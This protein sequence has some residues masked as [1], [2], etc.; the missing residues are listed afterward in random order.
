MKNTREITVHIPVMFALLQKQLD[1]SLC[2]SPSS[3]KK[4]DEFMI[5]GEIRPVLRV[6]I[7]IVKLIIR[8]A[9][10]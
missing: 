5:S 7:D 9:S 10:R 4:V 1:N 2:E 3:A 6:A 8:L